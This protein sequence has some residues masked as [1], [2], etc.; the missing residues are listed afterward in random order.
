MLFLLPLYDSIPLIIKAHLSFD[1][2]TAS[3]AFA[4]FCLSSRL[5]DVCF[6]EHHESL[7]KGAFNGSNVDNLLLLEG[8]SHDLCRVA[9][10]AEAHAWLARVAAPVVAFLSSRQSEEHFAGKRTVP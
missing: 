1:I 6:L 5:T 9:D 8:F 2:H 10:P 4:F 7:L 3:K